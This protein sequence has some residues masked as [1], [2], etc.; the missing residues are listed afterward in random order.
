MSE[1]NKK[2]RCLKRHKKQ[3]NKQIIIII[4]IVKSVQTRIVSEHEARKSL[5]DFQIQAYDLPTAGRPGLIDS[6][7]Q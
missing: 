7:N 5:C 3:I 2:T 4:I 6:T 1:D